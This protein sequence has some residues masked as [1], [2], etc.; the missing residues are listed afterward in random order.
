MS[1][2]IKA[3]LFLIIFTVIVVVHE[4]G[5]CVIGKRNGISVK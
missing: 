1:L 4:G 2:L 5:H 3:I